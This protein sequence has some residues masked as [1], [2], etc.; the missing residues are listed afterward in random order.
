M[1]RTMQSISR[2]D[3]I[4]VVHQSIQFRSD[5]FLKLQMITVG[6]II[7]RGVVVVMVFSIGMV[8]VARGTG[9]Q[10]LL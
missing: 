6:Q 4:E 8:V 2:S 9:Q 10:H 1:Q 5:G 7:H 3:G